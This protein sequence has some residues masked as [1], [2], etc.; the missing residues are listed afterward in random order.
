MER[1]GGGHGA[2]CRW[3][4]DDADDLAPMAGSPVFQD[5]GALAE[6]GADGMVIADLPKKIFFFCNPI[7]RAKN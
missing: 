1:C 4:E 5:S 7:L 2:R 6:S 3:H